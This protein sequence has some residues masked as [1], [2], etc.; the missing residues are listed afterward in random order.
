MA[1]LILA[2]C[3]PLAGVCSSDKSDLARKWIRQIHDEGAAGLAILLRAKAAVDTGELTFNN[4]E[5]VKKLLLA[6]ECAA[7]AIEG[8]FILDRLAL[9]AEAFSEKKHQSQAYLDACK[10][11]REAIVD[12]RVP[13]REYGREYQIR[14]TMNDRQYI[15]DVIRRYQQSSAEVY[16]RVLVMIECCGAQP[17]QRVY[18]KVLEHRVAVQCIVEE[19]CDRL[20]SILDI[21][22]A[23]TELTTFINR[24][25]VKVYFA[26]AAPKF[27]NALKAGRL[28]GI[29]QQIA[30]LQSA[31]GSDNLKAYVELAVLGSHPFSSARW[32]E[33]GLADLTAAQLKQRRFLH[34]HYDDWGLL[35]ASR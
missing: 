24:P 8:E 15:D 27:F 33:M 6:T 21:K 26:E 23:G 31:Q 28:A 2:L 16:P 18:D 9:A 22:G 29:E 34:M 10:K 3:W 13:F 4:E 17:Q 1:F 19:E 5:S 30:V 35:Q 12:Y 25:V 20:K 32:A 14:T 11:Y 7:H